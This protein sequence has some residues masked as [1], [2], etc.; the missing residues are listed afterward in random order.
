MRTILESN[1]VEN[2]PLSESGLLKQ[3]FQQFVIR[4]LLVPRHEF[5]GRH[6]EVFLDQRTG[7]FLAEGLQLAVEVHPA[8]AHLL[9]GLQALDAGLVDVRGGDDP[10]A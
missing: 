9:V 4:V 3:F 2:V 5:A 6:A 10:A 1:P 8:N 7:R